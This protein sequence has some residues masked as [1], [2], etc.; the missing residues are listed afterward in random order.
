MLNDSGSRG[1]GV[2]RRVRVEKLYIF[3]RQAH[4]D[5]HTSNTTRL[6]TPRAS[7]VIAETAPS[8]LAG[9]HGRAAWLLAED[10]APPDRVAAHLLS[11]ECSGEARVVEALRV[12]AVR[13]LAQGAPE[14]AVAYLRR[15]ARGAAGAGCAHGWGAESQTSG[16]RAGRNVKS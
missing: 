10:G 16:S 7:A 8:R 4:T 13:A 1:K 6:P 2:R 14:A 12:A 9:L 5:L 3:P 11:A 15:G